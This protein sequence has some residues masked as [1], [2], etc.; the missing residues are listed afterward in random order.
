MCNFRELIITIVCEFEM[1]I[2][3]E[4][5]IRRWVCGEAL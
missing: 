4:G 1:Q 5:L 2:E 3:K